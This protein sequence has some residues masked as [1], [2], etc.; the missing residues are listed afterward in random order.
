MVLFVAPACG[1]KHAY[2]LF[3]VLVLRTPFLGGCFRPQAGATNS[4]SEVYRRLLRSV[5]ILVTQ[6]LTKAEGLVTQK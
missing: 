3:V 6:K 2:V 4:L 1:R 5:E